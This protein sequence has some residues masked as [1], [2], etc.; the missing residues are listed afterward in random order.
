ME[1][2]PVGRVES[3]RTQ[4]ADDGWGGSPGRMQSYREPTP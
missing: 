4:L 3:G 1:V 2:E